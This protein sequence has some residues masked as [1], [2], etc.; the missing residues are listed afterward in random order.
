MENQLLLTIASSLYKVR[1]KS[2]Y[3]IWAGLGWAGLVFTCSKLSVCRSGIALPNLTSSMHLVLSRIHISH[4]EIRGEEYPVLMQVIIPK[5]ERR[6]VRYLLLYKPTMYL[7]DLSYR[8][9][10]Y[11]SFAFPILQVR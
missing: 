5:A 11:F 8:Q 7:L 3:S 6:L 4:F 9:S 2:L 1:K 10:R